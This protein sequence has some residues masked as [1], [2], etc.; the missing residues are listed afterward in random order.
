MNEFNAGEDALKQ[1]KDLWVLVSEEE[2]VK[3]HTHLTNPWQPVWKWSRL[4]HLMGNVRG[5][6]LSS[7]PLTLLAH[8]HTALLTTG[9]PALNYHSS[10]SSSCSSDPA[11]LQAGLLW[12]LCFLRQEGWIWPGAEA[13]SGAVRAQGTLIVTAAALRASLNCLDPT[14]K[15]PSSEGNEAEHYVM[16][17]Q[18]T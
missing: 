1:I 2:A 15:H 14:H 10:Q 18:E 7:I 12:G 16:H 9:N 3:H 11:S 6:L 5:K 4:I 13:D 8:A 17:I